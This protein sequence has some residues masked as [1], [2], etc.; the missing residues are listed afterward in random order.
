M[1]TKLMLCVF[2][3]LS[4]VS[5]SP[6]YTQVSKDNSSF[7]AKARRLEEP[8][9]GFSVSAEFC[10]STGRCRNRSG[11]VP[12]NGEILDCSFCNVEKNEVCVN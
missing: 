2:V 9:V 4:V 7:K 5:A 12:G 10:A 6:T 1:A 11:I 3:M 8:V